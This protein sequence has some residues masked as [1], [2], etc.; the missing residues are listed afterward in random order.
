MRAREKGE[1]PSVRGI[2]GNQNGVGLHQLE[3][4]LEPI[5]CCFMAECGFGLAISPHQVS[6]IKI[7]H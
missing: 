3:S 6:L 1:K 2:V 7:G 4:D 5:N